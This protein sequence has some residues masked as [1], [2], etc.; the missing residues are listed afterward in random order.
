[1]FKQL[2]IIVLLVIFSVGT[3]YTVESSTGHKVGAQAPDFE[4][5]M[6]N[7]QLQTLSSLTNKG[8]ALL[9]FWATECVYCYAHVADLKKLHQ[10]YSGKGLS[11][12][13]I[14]I[15]GEY[16]ME[17]KQYVKDNQLNYLILSDR[18]NNIGVAEAYHVFGTPT[19]VL[20]SDK[21][22]IVYRGHEIP[23]VSEWVNL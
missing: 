17:V 4:L 16:D 3:G 8:H 19:F 12:A 15:G 5:K 9:V 6:L 7:G 14:N 21:G 23:D 1:M 2:S 18:V 13:A 10:K 11:L 20:I 22:K